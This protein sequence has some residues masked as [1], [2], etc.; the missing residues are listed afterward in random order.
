MKEL[1]TF[2]KNLI[3]DDDA[4]VVAVSS[5]VD[6]MVLLDAI[7]TYINKKIIVVHVNHKARKEA[8]IEEKYLLDYCL[9]NNL[10]FEKTE[11]SEIIFNNFEEKARNF[12]LNFFKKIADKY[13]T[14]YIFTAHHKDDLAETILMTLTRGGKISSYQGFNQI[15]NYDDYIF[16]KPLINVD[17]EKIYKNAKEKKI[18]YFEDSTNV[19]DIYTRNRFRNKIIP[20]LKKENIKFLD[21]I[22]NFS[23]ELREINDYLDFIIKEKE[24]NIIVDNKINLDLLRKEDIFIQKRIIEIYLSKYLKIKSFSKRNIKQILNVIN[25]NGSTTVNLKNKKIY[26]LNNFI[27]DKENN[28]LISNY[29]YKLDLINPLINDF[30]IITYGQKDSSNNSIYLNS[31]EIKLPLYIRNN[32]KD[33]RIQIKNG[34]Q[35]VI[36]VL[37]DKKVNRYIRTSYPVICDQNNEILFIPFIKKSIY[38]KQENETYDII[39]NCERK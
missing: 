26:K 28:K 10:I 9:N 31:K 7:K 38:A 12:R 18:I 11:I 1:K 29:N 23:E 3:I 30:M 4:V 24:I 5:G 15:N 27:C 36:N 32:T 25:Q 2:L 21:N 22:Y 33:D 19:K 6:S 34:H 39:I 20:L 17:K 35:K 13:N 14:K 16:I 37:K 8:D